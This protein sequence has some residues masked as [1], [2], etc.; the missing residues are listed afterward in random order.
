MHG[1]MMREGEER[2]ITQALNENS[3]IV[4]IGAGCGGYLAKAVRVLGSERVLGV[5]RNKTYHLRHISMATEI[6][7]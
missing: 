4:D 3:C 2:Q 5:E 7:D 6:Q 1:A